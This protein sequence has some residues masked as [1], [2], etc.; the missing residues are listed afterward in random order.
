MAKQFYAKIVLC[1]MIFTVMINKTM[2]KRQKNIGNLPKIN[3]LPQR[4]QVLILGGHSG[5]FQKNIENLQNLNSLPQELQTLMLTG[6]SAFLHIPIQITKKDK[7]MHVVAFRPLGIFHPSEDVMASENFNTLDL[8]HNNNFIFP[9]KVTEY[10][11]TERAKYEDDSDDS[12][13]EDSDDEIMW[14]DGPN[15]NGM[16]IAFNKFGFVSTI[17]DDLRTRKGMENYYHS[18]KPA[19]AVGALCRQEDLY[20]IAD[21]LSPKFFCFFKNKEKFVFKGANVPCA[22]EKISFITPTLLLGLATDGSLYIIH[23]IL[24]KK[25]APRV[26]GYNQTLKISDGTRLYPKNF[27]VNSTL[28]WLVAIYSNCDYPLGDNALSLMNLKEKTLHRLIN[29]VD[30]KRLWFNNNKL[31]WFDSQKRLHMYSFE[32]LPVDSPQTFSLTKIIQRFC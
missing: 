14:F 25:V 2:E 20:A 16:H 30:V 18:F 6:H 3:W 27:A 28:P 7:A 9:R 11:E 15:D 32:L 5:S 23:C 13:Y 26:H 31:G 21:N 24:S 1:M 19:T 29:N 4:L 22:L 12:D 17:S 10:Y 8:D